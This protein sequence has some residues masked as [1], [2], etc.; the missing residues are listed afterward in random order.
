MSSWGQ[1]TFLVHFLGME[2]TLNLPPTSPPPTPPPWR[3][4]LRGNLRRGLWLQDR[5]FAFPLKSTNSTSVK[6]LT[7]KWKWTCFNYLE[8][9]CYIFSILLVRPSVFLSIIKYFLHGICPN[10]SCI[11]LGKGSYFK[12][13]HRKILLWF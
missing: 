6:S 1:G 2:I 13:V 5:I 9:S 11:S 8:F 3:G 4:T 10:N 12:K 7:L